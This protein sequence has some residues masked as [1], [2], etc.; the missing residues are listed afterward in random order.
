MGNEKRER[1]ENL[2]DAE[3]DF[4]K[5]F[6]LESG[7]LKEMAA[8]YG[9]SYPTVR[10]RLDRLIEK[11]KLSDKEDLSY[12]SLIKS[13]AIDGK[14]TLDAAKILIEEYKKEGEEKWKQDCLYL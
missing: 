3:I 7:S 5:R 13:M 6:I 12:V 1:I 8:I 9:V 11:I 2:D 14:I 10:L 4:I